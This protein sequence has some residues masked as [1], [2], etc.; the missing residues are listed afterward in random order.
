MYIFS[1]PY[2]NTKSIY[3]SLTFFSKPLS[4]WTPY[5]VE[6]LQNIEHLSPFKTIQLFNSKCLVNAFFQDHMH[7]FIILLQ[8]QDFL[9]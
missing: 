8:D 6:T 7:L 9:Q 4:C 5:I 2:Y 3:G 1:Y